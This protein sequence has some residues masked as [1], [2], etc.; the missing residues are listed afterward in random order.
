VKICSV[1]VYNGVC[2]GRLDNPRI[3]DC[4][5]V[6]AP[7]RR[8]QR[9]AITAQDYIRVTQSYIQSAKAKSKYWSSKNT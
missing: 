5:I 7:L 3:K 8:L 9:N 1:C 4:C 2:V 6:E